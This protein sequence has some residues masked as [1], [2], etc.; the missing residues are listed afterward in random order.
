M[1][2]KYNRKQDRKRS[3]YSMRTCCRIIPPFRRTLSGTDGSSREICP[4]CASPVPVLAVL[5]CG[6]YF[7]CLHPETL[8]QVKIEGVEQGHIAK[9]RLGLLR[10]G[11]S[12]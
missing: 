6:R 3:A 9:L 11:N 5:W 12:Q 4:S 10:L 1:C 2:I 7:P 8:P